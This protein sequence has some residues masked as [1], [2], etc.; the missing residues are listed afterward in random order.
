MGPRHRSVFRSERHYPNLDI[1]GAPRLDLCVY[2]GDAS[3]VRK[4]DAGLLETSD[5]EDRRQGSLGSSPRKEPAPRPTD[6][7][8]P[9]LGL[10][11]RLPSRLARDRPTGRGT[12]FLARPNPQATS[13]RRTTGD[14]GMTNAPLSDQQ[15][16]VQSL[17]WSL[18]SRSGG[19][20]I[21]E[22]GKVVAAGEPGG[23]LE[24]APDSTNDGASRGAASP[25]GLNH[26]SETVPTALTRRRTPCGHAPRAWRDKAPGRRG[27]GLPR[28]S[29]SHP[30]GRRPRR[31]SRSRQGWSV[32]RAAWA[33]C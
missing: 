8:P 12:R 23:A 5:P 1:T 30:A 13:R 3:F 2:D 29:L 25:A 14:P 4:L 19:C 17:R 20:S 31:T 32:R 16:P 28:R 15:T 26:D 33:G 7:R 21:Q 18:R 27:R 10:R 6:A 11:G 22:I 9:A 24:Q